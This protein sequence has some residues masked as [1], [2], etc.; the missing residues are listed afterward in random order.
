MTTATEENPTKLLFVDDDPVVLATLGKGLRN[1]GYDVVD[2]HDGEEALERCEDELP[3]LAILDISMPKVSGIDLGQSMRTKKIPFIYLTGIADTETV[4]FAVDSGALGYV[5]KPVDVAK[6][7]PTIQSALSRG[8][9]MRAL[10]DESARMAASLESGRLVNVAVGIIMERY[11]LKRED[12]FNLMRN[13]ARGERRK[14]AAVAQE[15]TD[16]ADLLNTLTPN[17]SSQRG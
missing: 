5:V 14:I 16:A 2:C 11:H 7:M 17:S 1:A 13:K 10:A 12:S 6:L 3:D 15:I 8:A 4:Q 9:E